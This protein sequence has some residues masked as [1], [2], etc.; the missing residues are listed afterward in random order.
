MR[1]P[2]VHGEEVS[3]F[4]NLWGLQKRALVV[5]DAEPSAADAAE[6]FSVVDV[7]DLPGVDDVN[8]AI[9]LRKQTLQP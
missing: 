8:G 7:K 4:R 6:L 1:R 3:S 9:D 2:S 5:W